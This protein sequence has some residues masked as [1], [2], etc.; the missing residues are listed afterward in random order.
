MNDVS[1]DDLLDETKFA[2]ETQFKLGLSSLCN[3]RH[4]FAGVFFREAA[5]QGNRRAQEYVSL[6]DDGAVSKSDWSRVVLD[7]EAK[8]IVFGE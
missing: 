5:R 7:R 2:H 6:L 4:G 8:H 1:S 3:G